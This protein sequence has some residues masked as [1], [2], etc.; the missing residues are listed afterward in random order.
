MWLKSFPT[1]HT[2][3]MTVNSGGEG[4]TRP[5]LYI[6]VC[7]QFFVGLIWRCSNANDTEGS[8][9]K[10]CQQQWYEMGGT[11]S[12]KNQN[13]QECQ[14]GC[15]KGHHLW[16]SPLS[17]RHWAWSIYKPQEHVNRTTHRNKRGTARGKLWWG[18]VKQCFEHRGGK[19]QTAATAQ[20]AHAT[21]DTNTITITRIFFFF[22][23]SQRSK[24][25]GT[26][27]TRVL[28]SR[29]RQEMFRSW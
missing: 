19:N 27:W 9:K 14:D 15:Y 4:G 20:N 1:H 13:R 24:S 23:S 16:T 10:I 29:R 8:E 3:A 18:T 28:P 17:R 21:A 25:T 6:N 22:Y 12:W 11:S 26:S 5:H 7:T 2:K